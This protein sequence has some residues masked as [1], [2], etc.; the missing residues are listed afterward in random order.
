MSGR[1]P[2]ADGRERDQDQHPNKC[3]GYP[4]KNT[5]NSTIKGET[6][7]A[8]PAE[9]DDA[10]SDQGGEGLRQ[11]CFRTSRKGH[12]GAMMSRAKAT[13][14]ITARAAHRLAKREDYAANGGRQPKLRSLPRTQPQAS[15]AAHRTI[16]SV[17]SER[18]ATGHCRR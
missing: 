12:T 9:G 7:T 4:Q 2:G 3:A 8:V 1:M 6:E 11:Y 18:L 15:I 17:S 14:V 5:A 13:G 10:S 16:T